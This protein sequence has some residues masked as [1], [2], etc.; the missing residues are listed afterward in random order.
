MKRELA[1]QAALFDTA[2]PVTQLHWGGGTPT[3]LSHGEM[4]ELM[5][6][7]ADHFAIVS[8]ERAKYS[9]EIAPREA[10]ADTIA[11]L[12]ELGFNRLSLG[13]QDCD[14]RV[15]RAV[16]LVQPRAMTEAVLHAARTV[17]SR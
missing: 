9:I 5:A 2:R 11:L 6:A 14:E 10:S 7:T 13:V 17:S 3:F 12:R 8:D 15:Q 4:C 16:N 1:M